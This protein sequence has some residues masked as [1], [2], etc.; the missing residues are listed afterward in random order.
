V[1][2]DHLAEFGRLA[3][4]TL[5]DNLSR[6]LEHADDLALGMGVAFEYPGLGLAHHLL[7]ERRHSVQFRAQS[8]QHC[9]LAGIGSALDPLGDLAGKAP[10]LPHDPR[11]GVEQPAVGLCHLGPVGHFAA[12]GAGD[13]SG[14]NLTLRLRSRSRV[15]IGPAI[16]VIRCIVRVSTRTPSPSSVLSVG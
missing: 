15:P 13:S 16:F 9:L 3:G 7:H 1:Q 14:R 8:L 2:F 12:G 10:R 6:R 11:R 5:P 4:L